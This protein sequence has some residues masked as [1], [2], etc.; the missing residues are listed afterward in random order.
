MDST[1]DR[2]SE[3]WRDSQIAEI[4]AEHEFLMS[5]LSVKTLPTEKLLILEGLQ[6][7]RERMNLAT[8]AHI[9]AIRE[10]RKERLADDAEQRKAAPLT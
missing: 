3:D 10:K 1:D 5:E 4:R 8:A 9:D 6:E 7:L 2:D